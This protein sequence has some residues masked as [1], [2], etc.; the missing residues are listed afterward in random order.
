MRGL[1][2]AIRTRRGDGPSSCS[3]GGASSSRDIVIPLNIVHDENKVGVRKEAGE[4]LTGSSLQLQ[5]LEASAQPYS[6]IG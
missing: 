2:A 6:S 5:K 4:E 1:E 3:V